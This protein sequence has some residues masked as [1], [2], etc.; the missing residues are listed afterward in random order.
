MKPILFDGSATNFNTNGLGALSD[1]KSCLVTEER[2]GIYEVEFE[3]PITGVR[4][5]SITTGRIILVSHDERKDLHRSISC[6]GWVDA[7]Q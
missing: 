5:E 3:Y 4:Y 2:N 7:T 1:C 6:A